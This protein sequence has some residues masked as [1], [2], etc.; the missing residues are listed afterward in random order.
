MI[1]RSFLFL[2]LINFSIFLTSCSEEDT[3]SLK[4]IEKKTI[5][6]PNTDRAVGKDE[7]SL[8]DKENIGSNP[9]T[10]PSQEPAV[11]PDTPPSQE[12]AVIPDISGREIPSEMPE[13]TKKTPPKDRVSSGEL[14]PKA[15]S[16]PNPHEGLT[17]VHVTPPKAPIEK[18]NTQSEPEVQIEQNPE[19]IGYTHKILGQIERKENPVEIAKNLTPSKVDPKYIDSKGHNLLMKA[20]IHGGKPILI[21]RILELEGG[22]LNKVSP[23]GEHKGHTPLSLAITHNVDSDTLADI[24]RAGAR[25]HQKVQEKHPLIWAARKSSG[26][27]SQ[28]LIERG[29]DVRVR[30]SKKRTPLIWAAMENSNVEVLNFL[31][32]ENTIDLVD[33]QGKTALHYAALRDEPTFLHFLITKGAKTDIEDNEKKTFIDYLSENENLSKTYQDIK[34]IFPHNPNY[35]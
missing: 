32:N 34:D 4:D 9:D 7:E 33:D 13:E 8:E 10:P 29:A 6:E 14:R 28:T 3:N 20:I 23:S 31:G 25:I 24:I 27:I 12:P 35:P 30:D 16:T 18:I 5:A 22:D 19:V 26:A 17:I 11:I 21:N 15:E 2:L 1:M